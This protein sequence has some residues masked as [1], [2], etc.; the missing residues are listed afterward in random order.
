MET[1]VYPRRYIS[2]HGSTV[3]IGLTLEETAEFE[4]LDSIYPLVADSPINDRLG[5]LYARHQTAYETMLAKL[6][7]VSA[8]ITYDGT[9][10][11]L[12]VADRAAMS[13]CSR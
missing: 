9:L 12:I 2:D 13:P 8:P 5:V 10:T 11:R 4:H 6:S 7:S 3:L 1:P